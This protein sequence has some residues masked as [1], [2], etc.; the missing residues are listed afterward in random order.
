MSSPVTLSDW[1]DR[2]DALLAPLRARFVP[3][4]VV[5]LARDGLDEELRSLSPL[6][7][8]KTARRGLPTAYVCIRGSCKLPTT[9][10]LVFSAQLTPGKE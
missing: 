3:N 5:L 8:G 1:L 2:E 4:K 6:L 9:D 10:P 7:E